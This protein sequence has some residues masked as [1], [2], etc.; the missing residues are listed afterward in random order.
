[1]DTDIKVR[2]QFNTIILSIID[3]GIE[4]S[5]LRAPHH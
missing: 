5:L 3:K 2:L 1:M 4:E